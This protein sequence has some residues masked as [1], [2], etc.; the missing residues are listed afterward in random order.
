MLTWAASVRA[1]YDEGTLW[2]QE[3]V[4]PTDGE[5]QEQYD[6]LLARARTL[7]SSMP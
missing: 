5:C 6:D 4:T 2:L 7:A 3:H 1:L